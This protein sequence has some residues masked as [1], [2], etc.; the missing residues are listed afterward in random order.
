MKCPFPR[1]IMFTLAASVIASCSGSGDSQ[2]PGPTFTVSGQI[3]AD[4]IF[5]VDSDLNDN[6]TVPVSN[7]TF[8]SAQP[9]ST[10]TEVRGYVNNSPTARL[11]DNFGVQPDD[12]DIFAASLEAGQV[13][14]L[15]IADFIPGGFI[16]LDIY[17]FNELGTLV[18]S[19]ISFSSAFE[20]I[21]VTAAGQYFIAVD[22]FE[23]ASNYSL[24]ISD[25]ATTPPLSSVVTNVAMMAPDSL[26]TTSKD[27]A[28]FSP[29]LTDLHGAPLSLSQT[30]P[31]LAAGTD[32]ASA[33][34]SAHISPAG[35]KQ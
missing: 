33:I 7:N 6:T 27:A 17:L 14:T 29:H 11:G 21:P 25:G 30:T 32:K 10:E 19:S 28:A 35:M 34:R 16:D 26:V 13:I 22:A 9:I 2:A 24:T 4:P 8:S 12:V 15:R 5:Q 18:S 20:Q 1:T 31:T 3:L 23:G